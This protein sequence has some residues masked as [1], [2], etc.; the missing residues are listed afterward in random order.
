MSVFAIKLFIAGFVVPV[1]V[2]FGLLYIARQLRLAQET[3]SRRRA[4]EQ[5]TQQPEPSLPAAERG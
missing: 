3:R 2:M 5:G 4:L 1:T